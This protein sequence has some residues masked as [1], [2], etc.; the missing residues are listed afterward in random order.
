M[1]QITASVAPY[2]AFPNFRRDVI[3]SVAIVIF[4]A[5]FAWLSVRSS[6]PPA[7]VGVE[8]APGMFYSGRALVQLRS[9]SQ[10]PH[11]VGS[12]EHNVV[13]DY[14]LR[15]ISAQGLTPSV[16]KTTAV[17]RR[18]G[19]ALRTGTVENLLARLPGT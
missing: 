7:A 8:A 3:V 6:S 14:I 15:E 9:I 17:N 4:L 18:W 2:V 11:P 13:R 16:Q 10:R 5:L 1:A 19:G 12:L